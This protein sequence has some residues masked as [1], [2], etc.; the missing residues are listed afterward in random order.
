MRTREEWASIIREQRCSGQ[1]QM[2]WCVANG[3]NYHTLIGQ[4]QKIRKAEKC[5][6]NVSQSENALVESAPRWIEVMEEKVS[7]RMQAA[8]MGQ[9]SVETGVFC[10]TVDAEFPPA[11]LAAVCRELARL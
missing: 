9:L 7:P 6:T 8:S 2:A 11:I 3:I 4:V 5:L 1:D 10:V